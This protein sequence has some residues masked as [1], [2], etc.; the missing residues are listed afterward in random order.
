MSARLI[1]TGLPGSGK[2][3]LCQTV[4]Q[5]AQMYKIEIKGVLSPPVFQSGEKIAI[6]LVDLSSGQ[7]TRLAQLRRSGEND[8]QITTQ[9]W[10]FDPAMMEKGSQILAS[11]TPCE[12]L[13]IDE[14]GPLE[15]TR[16]MGWQTGLAAADSGDFRS[17]LL[18]IRP[19]SAGNCPPALAECAIYRDRFARSGTRPGAAGDR[20]AW[21][22]GLICSFQSPLLPKLP[23]RQRFQHR[24]RVGIVGEEQL[25]T[26]R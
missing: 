11:S 21:P 14:L 5:H 16:K 9:R 17:A 25:R 1:I 2:S 10:A 7:R 18:V 3:T 24:L 15:F 22:A 4:I 12:L 26:I 23:D 6:D 13:V 8:T 20:D 19:R